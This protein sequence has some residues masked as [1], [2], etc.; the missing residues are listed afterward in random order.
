[1]ATQEGERLASGSTISS[2]QDIPDTITRPRR[3]IP[4]GAENDNFLW[5]KLRATE[6]RNQ[7]THARGG[8]AIRT[9]GDITTFYFL[10]P[11]S[12]PEDVTHSWEVYES[13]AS[14]L[15]QKGADIGKTMETGRGVL[16]GLGE[17]LTGWEKKS[18]K[19]QRKSIINKFN[20]IAKASGRV[21]AVHYRIDTPLTYQGSDRRKYIFTFNL[22][23]EGNPEQD[24][25][26]PIRILQRLS[27]PE[28]GG[29]AISIKLPCVFS[30]E[31]IPNTKMLN[32]DYAALEKVTSTYYGPWMK[33]LPMR[34]EVQCEFTDLEPLYRSTFTKIPYVTISEKP[35][36][37]V[38]PEEDKLKPERST[39]LEDR[40]KNRAISEVFSRVR[41]GIRSITG[42]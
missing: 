27:S 32:V 42:E 28:M 6:L 5:I 26:L 20:E 40:L 23:D 2:H 41:G 16:Q 33:G 8:G 18:E 39:Y 4:R 7:A 35:K 22:F 34:A 36:R 29:S 12:W 19:Q 15:L 21:A 10:A 3:I 38:P 30:I 37:P 14:R 25:M 11:D 1:M 31:T 13:F 17:T 9:G 24:I